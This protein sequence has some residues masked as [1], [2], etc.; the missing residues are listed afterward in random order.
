MFQVVS[1]DGYGETSIVGKFSDINA[2][3]ETA[4]ALVTEENIDNALTFDEKQKDWEAYFVEVLDEGGKFTTEAIYGGKD[5]GQD[6]VYHFKDDGVVRVMLGELTV[7]MRFY[8]GTDNKAD[9][10]ASVVSMK[11]RGKLIP[12][13]DLDH[14]DLREKTV[15][16]I[17]IV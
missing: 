15:Y 10:Y 12:I 2:A 3:V 17:K 7:P 8:I 16:Y 9:L 5:R 1:K 14:L 6:F 4:K 11:E 13:T